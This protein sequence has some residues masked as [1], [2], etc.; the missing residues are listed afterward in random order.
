MTWIRRVE[1]LSKL[2]KGIVNSLV[3]L[4]FI[5]FSRIPSPNAFSKGIALEVY[6]AARPAKLVQ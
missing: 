3:A 4:E 1:E 6:E 2:L 5:I